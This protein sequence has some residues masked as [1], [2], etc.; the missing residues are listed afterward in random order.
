MKDLGRSHRCRN[1]CRQVCIV[2]CFAVLWFFMESFTGAAAETTAAQW[3]PGK[4]YVLVASIVEWPAKAG[5]SSF[6]GERRY[7]DA[8]VKQ[9]KD[10][11][12]SAANIVFLRDRAATQSAMRGSL[13]ALAGRA[14]P[15]ST[16]LFYFQGHGSRNSLC[17]YDFDKAAADRTAFNTEQIPTILDKWAGDRLILIGDCCHSGS[18]ASVV[19]QFEKS[20]PAIRA[21]CFASTTATNSSTGNW[22][23]IESLIRALGGDPIVDQNHDGIITV[24]ETN[25]YIHDH[26]KYLENQL[27]A[28]TPS[29]NFE[30]DFVLTHVNP[31]KSARDI[32]GPYRIGDLLSAQDQEGKWYP[33]EI[34]DWRPADGAYRVH[35]TGWDPKWDEWVGANRLKRIVKPRLNV[36][37]RYE[38]KWDDGNYY[39]A[40]VTRSLEDYFYYV[41]YESE[42][43]DDDEWITPERSRLPTAKTA[44]DIPQFAALLPVGALPVGEAVAAQWNHDWY[45]GKI[46]GQVN[47]TYAIRYDDETDGKVAPDDLIPIA[48]PDQLQ[49]GKRV[50]ACRDGKPQMFAGKVTAVDGDGATIQWET[51]GTPARVPKQDLALIK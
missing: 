20:R 15:G 35:F 5:L 22:T 44:K 51:G 40:S 33:S 18:L 29:P 25:R 48:K 19:R 24:T 21:A 39:L 2:G 41:H 36:G 8:F 30:K 1:C 37:Q 38:V 13:A 32:P 50:L 23:F 31:H 46:T 6:K 17:C 28:F 26:M 10:C 49:I 7:D 43:G 14:G 9:L 27:A 45:R 12:V 47:G 4:T 42:A 16:L 11:G 34:L 3:E